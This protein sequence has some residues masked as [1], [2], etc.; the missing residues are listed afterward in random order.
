[1]E[2]PV[3]YNVYLC[4]GLGIGANPWGTNLG[5]LPEQTCNAI[6]QILQDYFQQIVGAHDL[7]PE[8]KKTYG[9]ALVQWVAGFPAVAPDELL[10]YLM[11]SGTTIAG[12]GS[13]Q[14]GRPPPGHDGLTN[15]HLGGSASEV[16]RHFSDPRVLANLMFHEAM[17]NKLALDNIGLHRRDGLA[18]STVTSPIT[19]DTQ[20]SAGNVRDMAE[21]LEVNRPQ[22]IAGIVKLVIESR[23]PDS[24]PAKGRF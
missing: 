16:Y 6:T 4:N 18:R 7:L 17:H 12:T 22:W 5:S 10:I 23:R 3:A 9:D 1:V 14:A 24:D 15:P 11:P 13:I 21:G 19:G 20:L 2:N 8:R